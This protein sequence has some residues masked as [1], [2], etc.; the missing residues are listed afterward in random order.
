MKSRVSWV[1]ALIAIFMLAT[2]GA[3]VNARVPDKDLPSGVTAVASVEGIDEY[4]LENGLRVILFPDPSKQ[5]ATVNI[6]YL[7]GS[8]HEGYGETGMAHLL[9]HLVFKGSTKHPNI[10]QELTAHGCRPNGST[11]FDRTNYFETFSATDE[12]LDWALDMEADRMVNSFISAEDLESEMTVVR[13]EFEIGENYPTYIIEERIYSTAFLWHN[14]GNTTIGARSDIEN[15]PIENLQAFYKRW[16]RPENAVLVVAGKIHEKKTLDLVQAKFGPIQNPE[17]PLQQVYTS[18]PAQ[19]GERSVTLR[20]VG[21]IQAVGVGY[22][23]PSGSHPDYPALQVMAFLLGDSPSGRLHKK[24]VET[25]KATEVSAWANRFRDPALM[26]VDAELRK[27]GPIEEVRDIMIQEI[28]GFAE[29]PP[30]VEDVE[31]A[32]KNLLRNWEVTMRDSPRAAIRLSEWAAMLLKTW[33]WLPRPT[34]TNRTARWG[35][36]YRRRLPS[37]LRFPN[38]PTWRSC[39]KVMRGAKPWPRVRS[40]TSRPRTSRAAFSGRLSPAG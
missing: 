4:R 17:T 24:L 39:S 21:D 16:Y 34:S 29:N 15:V 14:Y 9:E 36:T 38:H 25:Q 26:Y 40:S 27:D 28:E 5:T 12:N 2:L 13:N 3:P 31:R 6:T 23:I 32:K 18:E 22:H 37:A 8:L 35:S 10:A 20:R 7:V 33:S 30:T 11:W 1:F 19:D